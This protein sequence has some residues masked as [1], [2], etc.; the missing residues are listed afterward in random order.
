MVP[1]ND[2]CTHYDR[3]RVPKSRSCAWDDDINDFD[4]YYDQNCARD[5]DQDHT[6]NDFDSS[7]NR[8]CDQNVDF[9][10]HSSRNC[11]CDN[12]INDFVIHY[13]RNRAR[14]YD[15]DHSI[16]FFGPLSETNKIYD[17]SGGGSGSSW[18]YFVKY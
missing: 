17:G 14:D 4:I 15:Q 1:I 8:N 9:N 18:K 6:I 11:A 13:D 10:I 16:M 5:Y 7:C 12:D 3:N 2:V